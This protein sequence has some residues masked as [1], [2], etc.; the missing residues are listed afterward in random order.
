MFRPI[1]GIAAHRQV[2]ASMPCSELKHLKGACPISVQ[3][4]IAI[5]R[6]MLSVT[7]YRIKIVKIGLVA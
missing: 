2:T 4:A 6:M 1:E 7:R 3:L 5:T